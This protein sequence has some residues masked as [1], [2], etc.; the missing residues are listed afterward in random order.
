MADAPSSHRPAAPPPW[1][2]AVAGAGIVGLALALALKRG[3]GAGI[4][5]LVCDPALER[6]RPDG[7]AFAIS[8]GARR[9]LVA[10]GV[11]G[12]IERHGQAVHEMV[13]TDSRLADPVRPVFLT[14]SGEAEPSEPYATM[15]PAEPLA[16]ALRAACEACGVAFRAEGVARAE[17]SARIQR[18]A[19]VGG[20]AVA[21][22]LLVACDG[23]RSRLREEA[24]IGWVS[25]RYPQ[26]G[27]AATVGHER[28]H[29]GRAFEHFLPA[30]PFAT[31]P[32]PP[33]GAS[34]YRSSIV[35]TEEESRAAA[36]QAL[37]PESLQ[38]EIGRRFGFVL[39][40]VAL[41]SG[42]HVHP[43]RFG[44]ARRF[45]AQRMALMGDAAHEIH[46]LA[47]QGLNLGLADA[48]A[49]AEEVADAVR[50]GLDP[51]AAAVLDAYERRRRADTVTMALATDGLNR[52]FSTDSMPTR[53]LR[54]L[55]LRLVDRRPALK[56]LFVARAAGIGAGDAR[57]LRGEAL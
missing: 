54:D 28:D 51:G 52:L 15:M 27:I 11:W 7:R 19:L 53:L 20:E 45:A 12:G 57:L 38:G 32:L 55:G 56:D 23:A 47:G 8:A 2:I 14:F 13:I 33:G 31:L 43:L 25:W 41:E 37:A 40:A 3:L 46:P 10:L 36:L 48:A 29:R 6:R 50:L 34:G 21:V 18:L 26:S 35:W 42:L 9:M 5:I 30:G 22:S 49:L 24:G 1:R 44:L 16:A 39:G 17:P 4:E